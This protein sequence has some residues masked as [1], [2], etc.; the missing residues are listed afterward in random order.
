MKISYR[1]ILIT[2]LVVIFI[3]VTTNLIYYSTTNNILKKQQE[4]N[5]NIAI[6]KFNFF[7]NNFSDSLEN[8]LISYLNSSDNIENFPINNSPLDFLI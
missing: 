4:S 1:L 2:F 5:L 6:S 7:Y 3:T 8:E